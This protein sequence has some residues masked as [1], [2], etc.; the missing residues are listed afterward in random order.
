VQNIQ[1]RVVAVRED[2][3]QDADKLDD[4]VKH[5]SNALDC[6]L[7]IDQTHVTAK[8]VTPAPRLSASPP[9]AG[10]SVDTPKGV[11]YILALVTTI[12]VT[13][14]RRPLPFVFAL[15]SNDR[16]RSRSKI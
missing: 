9:I 4:M 13:P 16:V 5:L 14:T 6:K 11:E 15:L 10:I 2:K 3:Q 8:D 7:W 12:A 1:Q